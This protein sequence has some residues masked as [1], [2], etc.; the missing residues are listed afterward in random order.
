MKL[1]PGHFLAPGYYMDYWL[2]LIEAKYPMDFIEK[3]VKLKQYREL[4]LGAVFGASLTKTTNQKH[5]VGLPQDE[6]SD[7]VIRRYVPTTTPK[8]TPATNAQNMQIQITRCNLDAGETLIGQIANKNKPA[9]KNT[10]LLVHLQGFGQSIN[11][12]KTIDYL[13]NLNTV[14]PMEV[15]VIG[16]I[17]KSTKE[18]YKP[19]TFIEHMVYPDVGYAEVNLT[20][21]KAFFTF[22][23]IITTTQLGASRE[24]KSFGKVLLLPPDIK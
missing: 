6:P 21:T 8:G 14:Y 13:K 5:Y 1:T 17:D 24:L 7:I 20:D 12:S 16:R 11:F 9:Y 2:K 4:W 22:P 3:S 15:I 19:G 18:S 10:I 23:P